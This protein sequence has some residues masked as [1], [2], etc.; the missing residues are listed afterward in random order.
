VWQSKKNNRAGL[1]FSQLEAVMGIISERTFARVGLFLSVVALSILGPAGTYSTAAQSSL[2][3]EYVL[4]VSDVTRASE[5]V[6]S[7]GG[8]VS[9]EMAALGYVGVELSID[10]VQLISRSALVTRISDGGAMQDAKLAGMWW[11]FATP[12]TPVIDDEAVET[13]VAGM[14]WHFA[15]PETPVV[16]DETVETSVAGMWWQFALPEVPEAEDVE[17][18]GIA[19]LQQSGEMTVAGMWWQF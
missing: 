3:Q 7:V 14:W 13:S 18:G 6:Q 4:K 2:T 15:T 12:E 5:L 1:G 16:D 19:E 9:H 8:K 10:Q 17:F 11:Q